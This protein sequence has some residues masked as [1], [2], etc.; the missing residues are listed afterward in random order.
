MLLALAALGIF[1]GALTTLAGQGGGL[2]L[3][4]VCSHLLGPHAALAVTA[5]ALLFGNLHRAAVFRADVDR[6]VALRM[7]AGALPGAFA[8][9]LVAGVAPPWL[10]QVMLVALSG[11]AIAR[12]LGWIRFGVP[13]AALAPAGLFVGGMTG[14][15][16]GAGVLLAPVLLSTGLTGRPFVGTIAVVAVAMHVGRVGAYASAG[17]FTWGLALSTAAVTLAI[18]AGNALGERVRARTSAKVTSRLEY[19][20]LVVC[21]A[22]SLAGVA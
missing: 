18:F 6:G 4:L 12:A 11:L 10:L 16:G 8:G 15:A 14:T 2:F 1:A 3:L 21:V 13:R 7:V 17:L 19:G 9:G 5:P 22:L 20:V